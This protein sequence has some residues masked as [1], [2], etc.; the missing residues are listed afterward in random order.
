[1]I[2]AWIFCFARNEKKGPRYRI[3]I[4]PYKKEDSNFTFCTS[5]KWKVFSFLYFFFWE[6]VLS[7]D[8]IT[9]PSVFNTHTLLFLSLKGD[10]L[11]FSPLPSCKGELKEGRERERKRDREREEEKVLKFP[12]ESLTVQYTV[13]YRTHAP[14]LLKIKQPL[15][16]H[17]SRK[18]V[19]LQSKWKTLLF[20]G[21]SLFC[22]GNPMLLRQCEWGRL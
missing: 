22:R 3:P 16:A 13:V 21:W 7:L 5:G 4:V 10:P 11:L 20:T 17:F 18:K 14:P 2:Y 19:I 15:H 9:F 12:R 8:I 6:K 1:M